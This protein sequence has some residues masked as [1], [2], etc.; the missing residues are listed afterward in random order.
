MVAGFVVPDGVLVVVGLLELPLFVVVVEFD[1]ESLSL[2]VVVSDGL[3]DVVPE[4]SLSVVVVF[5][6]RAPD[7][8]DVVV[9]DEE[10]DVPLQLDNIHTEI[11]N[12][13]I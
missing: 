1:D 4:V 8:G 9:T 6:I 5:S 10:P 12:T 11:I 13:N 3:F 2:E 7:E